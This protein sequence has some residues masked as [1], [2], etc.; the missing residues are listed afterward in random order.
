M[1]AH[2]QGGAA[3]PGQA[4][5]RTPRSDNAH[6]AVGAVGRQGSA[7]TR[8]CARADVQRK[9]IATL[10][11]RAALLGLVLHQIQD[12]ACILV[13]EAGRPARAPSLQAAEAIVYGC[14][15]VRAE[16]GALAARLVAS[17][18]VQS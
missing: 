6:L 15:R 13:G 2:Q 16:I 12:G 4:T 10:T 11:A 17:R 7:D 18:E 8:D 3:A 1:A 5:P 14:E 9:R